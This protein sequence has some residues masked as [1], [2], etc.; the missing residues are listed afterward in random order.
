MRFCVEALV[1]VVWATAA[2]ATSILALY[3]PQYVYIASDAQI[4]ALN[5][6][7]SLKGCKIHTENKFAWASAGLLY[8]TAGPFDVRRIAADALKDGVTF[9]HAVDGFHAEIIRH[10]PDVVRRAKNDGV[11]DGLRIDIV[12]AA[13]DGGNLRVSQISVGED[14]LPSRKDC[15][16]QA[17][18]DM[19]VFLLGE[20]RAV[21][22]ILDVR[23][24]I[25][26]EL[27]IVNA[28]KFLIN[29]QAQETPS[30]V[31]GPFAVLQLTSRGAVLGRS[32]RLQVNLRG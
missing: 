8:Q 25:W 20:H 3:T 22:K 15:P 30:V 1:L 24:A 28:M 14:G 31:S 9:S 6:N 21:D 17:C 26:R 11:K 5:G 12:V 27:G 4:S 19:G 10:F 29:A 18:G 2:H 7:E 32:W 23:H 16:S 13:F